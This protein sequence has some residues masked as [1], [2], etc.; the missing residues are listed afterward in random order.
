MS[1]AA[2]TRTQRLRAISWFGSALLHGGALAIMLAAHAWLLWNAAARPVRA[3]GIVIEGGFLPARPPEP[4]APTVAFDLP[5]DDATAPAARLIA[6][7]IDE[8]INQ[9]QGLT[10]DQQL[11]ELKRRSSEL[12]RVSSAESIDQMARQ[13][14]AF[15][16]TKP[17]AER[18][19]EQPVGGQFDFNTAQL[20][21]VQRTPLAD[22]G[23]RYATVLVDAQGRKFETDVD[24][25]TGEQLFKVF[26][27]IRGNPLLEKVYRQVVMGLLDKLTQP[28]RTP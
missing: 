26:E 15:L 18:P 12:G 20:H 13:L 25:A 16:G 3:T 4:P 23:F 8:A 19:A 17:R 28:S 24:T 14:N 22:G 9:A 11:D 2:P 10:L 27:I 21:D 5:N 7:K 6:G 1:P